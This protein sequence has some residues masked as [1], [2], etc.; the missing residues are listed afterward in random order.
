MRVRNLVGRNTLNINGYCFIY[1]PNHPYSSSRGYV[2]RSRI[3][4][5]KK[6]KRVLEKEEIIH[7]INGIKSDDRPK[8]LKLFKNFSEHQA[9]HNSRRS[10]WFDKVKYKIA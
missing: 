1:Y 10:F 2:K 5:E 3:V 8:N 6:L 7:H 9:F 4:M